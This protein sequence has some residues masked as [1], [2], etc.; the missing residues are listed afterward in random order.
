MTA[1]EIPDVHRSQKPSTLILPLYENLKALNA[2]VAEEFLA[3]SE[4]IQSNAT[5]ARAM[6]AASHKAT[7]SDATLSG[8]HSVDTLKR[9]MQDSANI[10]AM[11][12][13]SAQTMV[14]MLSQ[15]NAIRTP[16]ERMNQV[17]SMLRI[18][19]VLSKIECGRLDSTI[20]DITNLSVDIDLLAREVQQQLEGMIQDI[21]ILTNQLRE[22]KR[23]LK[24]FEQEGRMETSD[25]IQ[26]TEAVLGPALRR[27]E[28]SLM[29]ARNIDEQFVAFSRST[30]KVVMSLQS[31]DLARQRVEHVQEALQRVA[32]SLD[33]GDHVE[34][35][36]GLLVLQRA[37][38][39]S[40]RNLVAD[41]IQTIGSS[42]RSLEPRIQDL[43][44]RTSLLAKETEEDSQSF[45]DLIDAS[46]ND[47]TRVFQ[48]C[49][50]SATAVTSTVKGVLPSVEKM[51]QY[52]Y[53]LRD[54]ESS[55]RLISLN[56]TVKTAQLGFEGVSMSILATEL[57]TITKQSEDHTRAMLEAVGSIR[58]ALERINIEMNASGG[59]LLMAEGGGEMV[60][61]ELEGLS[62][63]V[64]SSG[65][66]TRVKLDEVKQVAQTLCSELKQGCE[67]AERSSSIIK[68]YDDQ[69]FN[70]DNVLR[71]L[72]VSEEML[73]QTGGANQ[74]GDL[75]K[76]YSMQSERELHSKIFG[77]AM[78]STE[79]SG[80]EGNDSDSDDGIELF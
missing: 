33:A 65:Q 11:V 36:A 39:L 58:T 26:R 30:D 38:L 76:L 8:N 41:S 34:S 64:R 43:L 37:Q 70:F 50:A 10:S 75:S 77:G 29:N 51:L 61:K 15:V 1:N 45:A 74:G 6:T 47:V 32:T 24:K 12:E 16:L 62:Q 28:A 60:G 9:I 46:L 31:E 20:S 66:Q 4:V 44:S 48:Q 7:G 2:R 13:V 40:T 59:S 35:C 55:V 18:V 17:R 56:A 73:T 49:S 57:Q 27:S 79:A 21:E 19:S 63:I 54:I 78:P 52:A 68:L 80:V 42:L 67:L 71:H 23:E 72:G 22:G 5:R 25:L 69:L 53:A 3:L 14:E